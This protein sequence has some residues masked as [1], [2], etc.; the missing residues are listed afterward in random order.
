M[1][2]NYHIDYRLGYENSQQQLD[3]GVRQINI[4]KLIFRGL[5]D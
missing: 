3:V 4:S 1:F 2:I 5:R